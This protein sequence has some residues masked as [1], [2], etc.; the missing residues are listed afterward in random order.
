VVWFNF[1]LMISL[2]NAKH[3]RLQAGSLLDFPILTSAAGRFF[4]PAFYETTQ[5]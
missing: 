1:V 5:P 4:A 3:N 2:L